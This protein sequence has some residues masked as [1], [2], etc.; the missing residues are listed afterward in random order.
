VSLEA[1]TGRSRRRRHPPATETLE[2]GGA[3]MVRG[4]IAGGAVALKAPLVFVGYGMNDA[5][6][7]YDDYEGLDVRGKVAVVLSGSPKGMDSEIGAHLTSEQG[8]VAAEHGA[9]AIV[10]VQ[11]RASAGA[12]PWEKVVEFGSDPLT[13]WQRRNS[14][15]S[16]PW[17][18]GDGHRRPKVA[19]ALFDGARRRWRRSSTRRT[20]RAAGRRVRV[21]IDR[22]HRRRHRGAPARAPR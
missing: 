15:R 12:F 3:V 4:P 21:E 20:S 7:G 13:T 9:A 18:Q 8:R 17:P 14:V 10:S 5:G 6:V 22:G 19:V 16:E 2:Q 1:L 11:T